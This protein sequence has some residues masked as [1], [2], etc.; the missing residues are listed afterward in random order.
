MSRGAHADRAR[1]RAAQ[2]LRDG[3]YV[4]LGI[5]LPTL[6]PQFL[7]AGVTVMLQS[8]NGVLGRGRTR[9][10]PKSIPT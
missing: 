3:Q 8:E 4:N 5:G 2:E 10:S 6:I 7:P 9:R 1:R